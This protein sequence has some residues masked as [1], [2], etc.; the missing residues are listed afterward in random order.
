MT[1]SA[2][3]ASCLTAIPPSLITS[4][5]FWPQKKINQISSLEKKLILGKVL[6]EILGII[7]GQIFGQILD[8]VLGE[9]KGEILGDILGEN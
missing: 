2:A 6:G 3:S 9:N 5:V 4:K 7:L 1:S 8:K